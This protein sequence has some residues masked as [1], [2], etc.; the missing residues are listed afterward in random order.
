MNTSLAEAFP[1]GGYLA[2][3]LD[4][5]GWSQAEFAEILGRPA[6][7]VSEIVSGKKE[8]TRESAAQIGAALG[9]SAELWLN[10]QDSYY[11]WKQSQNQAVLRQLS[12]VKIRAR[13]NE[14]APVSVLKKRGVIT[15]ADPY[16][17]AEQLCALFGITDVF[18][19]PNL[20]MAAKRSNQDEDVTPVQKTWLAC[21]YR[22]AEKK[23]VGSYSQVGLEELGSKLSRQVKQP[24]GFRYLPQ[25]FASVGVRLV[26]VEAFPSSKIDGASFLLG[27]MPVIALSGRGQRMDK[28]LFALLH[29]AAHVSLGHIQDG[30]VIDDDGSGV[31]ATM[32]AGANELAASW[33]QPYKMPNAPAR[34]GHDW[35]DAVAQKNGI[36]PIIVIGQLQNAGKINWRSALVKAAPSVTEYLHTWSDGN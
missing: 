4:E 31:E 35:V 6:Q 24:D 32:E 29:E 15:A 34:I 9:T 17:Q 18:D 3:E 20:P 13:C 28:V 23:S 2:D 19:E 12:E 8:I 22:E 26:Y 36:H 27:E 30:I 10:L 1:A 25:V 5:R 33:V 14:L 7:F 11:L 21:A 16:G